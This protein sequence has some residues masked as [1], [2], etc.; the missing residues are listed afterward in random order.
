MAAVL[1]VGFG[2]APAAQADSAYQAPDWS[3]DW[4]VTSQI[5]TDNNWSGVAGILGYNGSDPGNSTTGLDP[6]TLTT[7]PLGSVAVSAN[8]MHPDN[9]TDVAVAEFEPGSGQISDPIVGI[10]GATAFDTPFL[11]LH[12]NG[13]G[14]SNINVAYDLIDIDNTGTNAVSRVALQ[15]RLGNSGAFINL[16][17]GCVADA[18]EGPNLEG[19]TTHISVTLPDATDNQA[20]IQVRIM[21]YNAAGSDEW[22]GVDNLEVTAGGAGPTPT[23]TSPGP[24]ATNTVPAPTSPPPTQDP[25]LTL[26]LYVPLVRNGN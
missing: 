9:I 15:Y 13:T 22:I 21:T 17:G 16:P 7:N 11:L 4:T 26:K 23:N 18:T 8:R 25:S 24:T 6:C 1:S 20:Q 3:Q 14:K 19:K 2:R 5:T 10:R 12:I